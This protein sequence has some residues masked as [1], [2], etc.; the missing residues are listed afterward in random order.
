METLRETN[1]LDNEVNKIIQFL[2][3]EIVEK[4]TFKELEE[5]FK[6]TIYK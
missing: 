5:E 4:I 1:L 6:I 3:K 2:E